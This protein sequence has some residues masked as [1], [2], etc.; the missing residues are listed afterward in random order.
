MPPD[1]ALTLLAPQLRALRITWRARLG[2]PDLNPMLWHPRLERVELLEDSSSF[3]PPIK[4]WEPCDLSVLRRAPRLRS[5]VLESSDIFHYS[6]NAEGEQDEGEG[7]GV[8]VDVGTRAA[9]AKAGKLY[10]WGVNWRPLGLKE[11]VLRLAGH[12]AEV[13]HLAWATAGALGATLERLEMQNCVLPRDP[14]LARRALLCLP[15]LQRLETLVLRL[16]PQETVGQEVNQ[17]EE[18]GMFGV[19]QGAVQAFFEPLRL[20][21]PRLREVLVVLPPAARDCDK[22]MMDWGAC[23]AA[24]SRQAWPPGLL[25]FEF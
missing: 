25:R 17:A 8:V 22:I 19:T 3:P 2:R 24:V 5:L 4:P 23:Y 11:L 12:P 15:Q 7:E 21:G 14:D 9:A 10:I 16:A 20:V 6:H 18:N 1:D 13:E